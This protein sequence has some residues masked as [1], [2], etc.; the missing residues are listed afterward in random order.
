VELTLPANASR[1]HIFAVSI[2]ACGL[3]PLDAT[4]QYIFTPKT[5]PLKPV[6]P[7]PAESPAAVVAPDST[8]DVD[9]AEA[10]H[11]K[12]SSEPDDEPVRVAALSRTRTLSDGSSKQDVSAV[13]SVVAAAEAKEAELPAAQPPVGDTGPSTC[14]EEEFLLLRSTLHNVMSTIPPQQVSVVFHPPP[15][16]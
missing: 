13:C 5:V 3:L 6:P 7:P 16:A 2:G 4:P 9:H 10:T 12:L 1:R 15:A 11:S 8:K 14:T